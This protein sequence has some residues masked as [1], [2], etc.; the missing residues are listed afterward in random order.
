MKLSLEF[1]S[2]KIWLVFAAL[3]AALGVSAT[4]IEE[5]NQVLISL[6]AVFE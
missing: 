1:N 5:I 4:Q 3:L 2:K 6:M